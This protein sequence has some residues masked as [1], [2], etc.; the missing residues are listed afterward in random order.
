[1]NASQILSLIY[2]SADALPNRELYLQLAREQSKGICAGSLERAVALRAA[3]TIAL[4]TDPAR[5]GGTAGAVVSKREGDL[6]ISFGGT[7]TSSGSF[8]NLQAT[9]FGQ[10]LI[11]LIKA[12]KGFIGVTGGGLRHG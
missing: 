3:H 4:A 8:G 2:P 1:M 5:A 12:C 10:E 11:A 7:T 6:S 9:S